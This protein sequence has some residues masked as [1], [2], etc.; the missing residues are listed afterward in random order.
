MKPK[1]Q[2][3][4]PAQQELFRI[5][6][7]RIVDLTHP[8]VKL[9]AR[10]DWQGLEEHFGSCFCDE[11]RPA[12]NTRLMVSLHYLKYANNLS[13]EETVVLWVENPYWQ[14]F[15]GMVYFE[16]KLPIHP[17]SMS[18]WRKRIGEHGAEQLLKQT[19]EQAVESKLVKPSQLTKVN[20]DTTVS[21][22][23]IA[24]PT[25]ARLYKKAIDLLVKTA[26]REHIA[27]RQS[28]QR[29][30]KE[31]LIASR[32]YAHARQM[33]R[34]GKQVKSLRTMLG[35]LIRDIQ[36]KVINGVSNRMQNLLEKATR[37]HTQQRND[38]N[39]I[40]SIHEP[41]AQCIS[42]GKVGKK[43]EFGH[44]VSLAVTTIGSWILAALGLKGNP[45]DGHTL[46]V[47]LEK[48]KEITG[49]EVKKVYVDRGYRNHG[50]DEQVVM[51]DR[52]RRGK[53]SKGV[54]KNLKHRSAIEPVIGHL[55]SD[56]RLERNYLQGE[57]G[58]A[59]NAILSAAGYN[60]R[61]ILKGLSLF[62]A[63][64][65]CLLQSKQHTCAAQS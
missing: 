13:N 26:K 20:V 2:P 57:E 7:D 15:S 9:S 8:L 12:I 10:M 62:F 17:S 3:S 48:V 64:F 42:K 16:H 35:R 11:G 52:A 23:N 19:I 18:R 27:L 1:K 56:C 59:I 53:L 34:A 49:K 38:K 54:W 44:K 29:V 39:K 46:S 51:V 37:I 47:T 5:E 22:S 4:K 33:K 36:R 43:Y 50:C 14:Y 6:L 30:S 63:L 41:G 24:F 21:L 40:Y 55:K 60:F 25:D 65:V 45:Y 32:R 58:N 31:A 28:Y 61:K